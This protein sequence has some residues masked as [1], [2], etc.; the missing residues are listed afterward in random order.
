MISKEESALFVKAKNVYL[1]IRGPFF[2]CVVVHH[3]TNRK[4][5]PTHFHVF[6]CV[7]SSHLCPTS[8]SVVACSTL[9]VWT[10]EEE[11]EV[12]RSG[13]KSVVKI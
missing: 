6:S 2:I 5:E 12:E 9:F 4:I 7:K 3:F 10:A 11:E 8:N 1:T 13:T